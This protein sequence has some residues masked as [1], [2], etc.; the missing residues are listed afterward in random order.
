MTLPMVFPLNLRQAGRADWRR[1]GMSA[2]HPQT[3]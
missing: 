3:P 1:S 2:A